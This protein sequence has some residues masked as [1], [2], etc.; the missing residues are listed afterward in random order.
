MPKVT[1]TFMAF[2]L[3]CRPVSSWKEKFAGCINARGPFLNVHTLLC[4][5][6]LPFWF[7]PS[8]QKAFRKYNPGLLL[9]RTVYWYHCADI[10]LRIQLAPSNMESPATRR[11]VSVFSRTAKIQLD[12]RYNVEEDPPV[13]ICWHF[14]KRR[15][16][17]VG[18]FWLKRLRL[19]ALSITIFALQAD[20]PRY[21]VSFAD[22]DELGR[23][24][25]APSSN[26]GPRS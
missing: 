25:D 3:F 16:Y 17:P 19:Q 9:H 8:T 15:M 22:F 13:C 1:W 11:T 12:N 2:C 6:A 20:A 7:G 4:N 5:A 18:W 14:A 21:N 10:Y 26:T 24:P 23:V